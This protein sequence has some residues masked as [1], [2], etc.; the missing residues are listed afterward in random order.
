LIVTLMYLPFLSLLSG[1]LGTFLS[2][3]W[4]LT[5]LRLSKNTTDLGLIEELPAAA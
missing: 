2:S 5:Y 3:T 1:I 4:T